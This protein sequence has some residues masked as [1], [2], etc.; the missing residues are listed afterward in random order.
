MNNNTTTIQKL[1][2]SKIYQDYER[3]FSQTTQ[4]PVT[5]RP[6]ESWQLPLHGK[7]FENRFCGLMAQKSA[8]CASCLQTQQ[9]LT[10]QAQRQPDTVLCA[11]GLADTAVPV[12]MG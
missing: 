3:A 8:S 4:M 12:Q 1:T 2:S 5:L 6:V 9:R 10:E 11:H 7:P